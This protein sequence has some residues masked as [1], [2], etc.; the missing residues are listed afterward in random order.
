MEIIDE[1]DTGTLYNLPIPQKKQSSSKYR[2]FI[3]S[4]AIRQGLNSPD[5]K[6]VMYTQY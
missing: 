5:S 4:R 2:D 6:H 3:L 1:V